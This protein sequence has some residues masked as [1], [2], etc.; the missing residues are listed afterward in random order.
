[1]DAV[2]R[3]FFRQE[4]NDG[5]S[6]PSFDWLLFL[7]T[8]PL[9]GAGLVTMN[10]FSG[11][12][13]LFSRQLV[14][15]LVSWIVCFVLSVGDFRF[16]RRTGVL[17]FLF[18]GVVMSLVALYTMGAISH[19]AQSWFS[20]GGFSFQP[21]DPAKLILIMVLA[22]YFSRRHVEI[23][24]W[25]HIV[26]SG[27]YAL[28]LF[29]LILLQPDF[30]SAIII[31]LIWLGMVLVSGISKRHLLYVVVAG[32]VAF[33]ILWT[34]VFATY[35]KQRIL[36]FLSP[37]TDIRGAGYNAYQS[38]I[39]I[40]SGEL[41]GKGVG[42]GTQSRL[43]FLPEYETDFIFAAFVEEWGF[44][45]ALLLFVLFAIVFWRILRNT[46]RGATNFE[47]LFGLGYSLY[48]MSHIIV[49]VGMN[50]GLLPVTG[51]TM[52]F[53]SYGGSH[54]LTEYA[55]LGILI[56][57]RRYRRVAHKQEIQ[58]EFVGPR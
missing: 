18:G 43:Q 46:M 3:L 49:H 4:R 36:T 15:V 6:V 24:H 48:L 23:A 51:L 17:L 9:V 53:M 19:G 8:V 50:L 35:Q 47:I 13:A 21:S 22:K 38:T 44:V 45:G 57:M 39:A 12:D 27:L 10:S 42:Y 14:W 33:I 11:T 56:A 28:I 40:G 29:I 58:N 54:L 2:R 25:F 7:A 32:A 16:L 37:L 1:M 41:F 20:F 26:V 55:G 5:S 34:S 52:P 31:F 30:G